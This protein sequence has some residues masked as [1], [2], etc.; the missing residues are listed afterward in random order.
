M[1]EGGGGRG[2]G[3]GPGPERERPGH[4]PTSQLSPRPP[5]HLEGPARLR[6]Q[7]LS[8]PCCLP[9]GRLLPPARGEHRGP[10]RP[11][12]RSAT[13]HI[14]APLNQGR[15]AVRA[16]PTLGPELLAPKAPPVPVGAGLLR[17][18][19]GRA[20][21]RRKGRGPGSGRCAQL[22][23]AAGWRRQPGTAAP[24]RCVLRCPSGTGGPGS[25]RALPIP[26]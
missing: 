12:G 7:S 14:T 22:R 15:R 8:I 19:R 4:F 16:G 25:G 21:L 23:G 6:A 5:L 24:S 2:S 26:S 1:P 20:R 13:P 18:L 17:G 9:S 11:P 10:A 3:G